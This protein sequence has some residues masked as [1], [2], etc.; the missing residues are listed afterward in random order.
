[1][2]LLCS[3]QDYYFHQRLQLEYRSTFFIVLYFIADLLFSVVVLML[4]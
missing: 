4:R 3:I 1:M 2:Y